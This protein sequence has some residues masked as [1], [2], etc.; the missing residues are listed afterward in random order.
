M[1]GASPGVAAENALYGQPPSFEYPMLAECLQ[2]IAGTGWGIAATCGQERGDKQLV[3]SDQ[4]DKGGDQQ[5]FHDAG[6]FVFL[7]FVRC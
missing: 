5:F 7:G 6:D 4:E 2:G 1:A 3:T